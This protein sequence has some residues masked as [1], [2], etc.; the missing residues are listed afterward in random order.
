MPQGFGPVGALLPGRG[1]GRAQAGGY[2]SLVLGGREGLPVDPGGLLPSPL[3]REERLAADPAVI[4]APPPPPPAKFAL[5]TGADKAF[6][7]LGC[8][9]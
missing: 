2:S 9:Q 1:A 6:P 4:G 5:L 8:P 7:R 3:V